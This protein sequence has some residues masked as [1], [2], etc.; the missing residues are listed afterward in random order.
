MLQE[1]NIILTDRISNH[2]L[3]ALLNPKLSHYWFKYKGKLTGN[4]LQIDKNQ[5]LPSQFLILVGLK[6]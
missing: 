1:L 3:T 6:N 5:L 2:I 4:L